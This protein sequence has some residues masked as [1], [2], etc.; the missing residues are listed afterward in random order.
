[1]TDPRVRGRYAL[2]AALALYVPLVAACGDDG[3]GGPRTSS[4]IEHVVVLVQEN[5]SFDAYFSDYCTAPTGS[6]PVCT[7]GPACCEAGPATDPGTGA[8]PLLLDDATHGAFDPIH[9]ST[10]FISEI[11][12][13]G[14]DQFVAGA[15]CG[16][17]P[18]NF[19]YAGEAQVGRFRDLARANA[20]ADRWYQPIVGASSANDMYLARAKFV[21]EDNSYVPEAIGSTCTLNQNLILYDDPTIG[22]LLTDARVG[23]AWYIQGYDV[24][25]DA[26]AEGQCPPPDPA[27][28]LGLPF[29]PCVYDP[30]DIPMQYY[31]RFTDDPTYFRDYDASFFRDLSEGTLPPVSF[32]KAIGFRSEH[33]GYGSTIT[34]GLDFSG[35]LVDAVL[36]S[37]YAGSTLVLITYD[38]DGGYFDHV[39]PPPT[40]PVDDK[41]YGP[42]VPTLA[43]GRFARSGQISHVVLEHSSIVKFIEWNW[44]GGETGQLG[45]RDAEV[46]NIGSLLDPAETGV[47]VPD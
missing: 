17:D 41:P 13:G 29:Y 33:P 43:I 7:D 2:G 26:V 9:F 46:N 36:S 20:L 45:T 27:C 8:G 23:W 21:F 3:G 32:V 24:M 4:R 37:R 40:S 39:A 42:R 5:T 12:G 25:N 30:S 28:P 22:D 44:L 47:A 11:N 38:E 19:A 6:D 1:M 18:R 31:R 35:A 16:S 34:A 15:V 14:M 10:C